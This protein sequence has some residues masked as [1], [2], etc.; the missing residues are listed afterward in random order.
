M[1][2]QTRSW[3]RQKSATV[4]QWFDREN[5]VPARRRIVTSADMRYA[6]QNYELN[7]SIPDLPEDG[8]LLE[9]LIA[10]FNEAYDRLYGYTAP[11]EGVEIITFRLEA[12]GVVEKP[13]FA[14]HKQ[15]GPDAGAAALPSREVYIPEAREFTMTGIYDRDL[16]RPG[17]RIKGTAV[18]E[19]M[20]ST[21]FVL[22]GQWAT[23]D[24]Y[25]NLIITEESP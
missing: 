15:A 7:V 12:Y 24:A 10:N 5:V 3:A 4:A 23:V 8:A 6:G 9:G 14:V 22:P 21:T 17:N 20:D 1:R 11:D 18:I 19:Q 2:S 16:L 13:Q 25:L